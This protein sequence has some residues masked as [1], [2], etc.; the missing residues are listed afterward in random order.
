MLL[1]SA[2]IVAGCGGSS[3]GS[4]TL[5]WYVFDEP[6]GAYDKAAEDCSKASNGRYTIEQELLPTD[7][8]VQR[9]QL[10]RRLGAEDSSIDIMGMDVIWTAEFANAGWIEEW[11][12]KRRQTVSEKVFPSVLETATFEGKL[13][14]APFTSN[15]QLLWYRTDR[16]KKP[17]KTWDEMIRM[18]EKLGADGKIQVQ[19]ARYEGFTVW[20]NQMIESAGAQVLSGPE[21]VALPEKETTRALEVMGQLANS[22]A[23]AT[24]IETSDEDSGRLNFQD[25]ASTFMVN[26]PFVYP[27][28]E[29]EAPDVFKVMGMARYPAVDA[30]RPSKPPLGGINLGVS[31]YSEKK[32]LAFEAAE[33][34]RS[35]ANQVIAANL[36]GLPPTR[37]DLYDKKGVQE[38]YPGFAK[39]LRESIEDAGPRPQTPAYQD[40][41][42]AIQRALHPPSN[43][44]P[45]DPAAA[46]EELKDKV[47]Q[48]VKR[49][50]VL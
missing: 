42:L 26:Y 40:V 32:D 37:S 30:S 2:A 9:E 27:S 36:G 18:A 15:T 48:G 21:T 45:E 13:Y 7:A 23:A 49:E 35:E 39:L 6:G 44:D 10:V 50:G 8:S 38:A 31:A 24:D 25:G 28:A 20:A 11:T 3:A 33:C 29:A 5:T 14:G 17:P 46:Y 19:A 1:A 12:G 34:L 16:V 4:G 41:S 47:D 22:P 43:I